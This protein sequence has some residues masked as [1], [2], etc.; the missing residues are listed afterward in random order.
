MSD[1]PG[2]PVYLLQHMDSAGLARYGAEMEAVREIARGL[3]DKVGEREKVERIV[4]C[5]D[6]V[7]EDVDFA[8]VRLNEKVVA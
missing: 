7:L 6:G 8:T 5:I 3:V 1:H 4:R 2:E